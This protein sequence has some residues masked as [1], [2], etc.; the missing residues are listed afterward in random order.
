MGSDDSFVL[1]MC[2][3]LIFCSKIAQKGEKLLEAAR[4]SKSSSKSQKLPK[5]CLG[6]SGQA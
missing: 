6:Q 4:T 5:S 1:E 3:K 2:C